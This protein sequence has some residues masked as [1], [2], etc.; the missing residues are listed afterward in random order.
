MLEVHWLHMLRCEMNKFTER[1]Y[2]RV[3]K[4]V[5]M[6]SIKFLKWVRSKCVNTITTKQNISQQGVIKQIYFKQ[7]YN[8]HML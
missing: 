5:Y 2:E 6:E 3:T 8:V 1:V 4:Q 7:G